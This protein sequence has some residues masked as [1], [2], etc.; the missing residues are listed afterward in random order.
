MQTLLVDGWTI[1]LRLPPESG[2][3]PVALLL[4]GW[5]GDEN[6]M[7][8]FTSRLPKQ[9]ICIAPRGI[10]STP[11]GGYG[12]YPQDVKA[13]PSVDDF[14]PT[15]EALLKML[16]M[17]NIPGGDFGQLYLVG[18]SQGAALAYTIA[19]HYPER[20]T[21]VAGLSGFLPDGVSELIRGQP[22]RSKRLFY[23]SWN[24]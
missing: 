12:W 7:W 8:I 11:L 5:T 13:W 22:L 17:V 9:L 3:H 16:T 10:Y 6:S 1:R 2:L 21:S 18:F 20:V 24:L 14:L 15:A 23:R 4:H 19:L